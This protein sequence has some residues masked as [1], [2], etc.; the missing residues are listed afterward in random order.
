MG[1]RSMGFCQWAT[2]VLSYAFGGPTVLTIYKG[3]KRRRSVLTNASGLY[4]LG[5][6]CP[7]P[8]AVRGTLDTP[9]AA[10]YF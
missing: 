9:P 8:L 3:E 6:V 2:L 7:V 5:P 4:S 10:A 1:P